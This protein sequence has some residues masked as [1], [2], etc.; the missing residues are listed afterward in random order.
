MAR[1]AGDDVWTEIDVDTAG[2]II[3][4][5]LVDRLLFLPIQQPK[6]DI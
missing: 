4:A 2:A 3:G 5:D 6:V 1:D